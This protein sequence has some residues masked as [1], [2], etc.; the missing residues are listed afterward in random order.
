[1]TESSLL[2]FYEVSIIN[3]SWKY[4]LHTLTE[5]HLFSFPERIVLH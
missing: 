4:V 2:K 1:M 3:F 5:I